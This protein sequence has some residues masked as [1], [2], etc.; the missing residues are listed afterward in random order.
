MDREPAH[1]TNRLVAFWRWL[2]NIGSNPDLTKEQ[3]K[4]LH[5]TNQA[6]VLCIVLSYSY[7]PMLLWLGLDTLALLFCIPIAI[8]HLVFWINHRQH[9]LAARILLLV[10]G[11]IQ[12]AG[13]AMAIGPAA[14]NILFLIPAAMSPFLYFS[15]PQRRYIF[16]AVLLSA[17]L[18]A[19][20]EVTFAYD[21]SPWKLDPALARWVNIATYGE[22]MLACVLFLLYFSSENFRTESALSSEKERSD[23][24][25]LNILPQSII[26]RLKSGETV[27]ADRFDDITVMFAD[28]AG[29]TPFAAKLTPEEVVDFLNRIFSSFDGLIE[30][31]RLEKIKTI[32]DAYMVVGGA[33]VANPAHLEAVLDMSLD[34]MEMLANRSRHGAPVTMRVGVHTGPAVAGIIGDKKWAYDLWGDTVNLASRLESHGVPGRIQVSE[35]VYARM[36]E[37]YCFE[38][39]GTIAVKGSG[40]MS[41]WFLTGRNRLDA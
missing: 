19:A 6:V 2:S 10:N 20:A 14:G 22:T 27:I 32:G 41:T 26:P 33:P 35:A 23:H 4:R 25:L 36:N 29:F 37:R 7:L 8:Y 17:V 5:L 1:A 12:I 3:L 30:T 16:S 9:Y 34:L 24:L 18:W 28:I 39:R 11:N 21:L 13:V 15:A 38:P 31:Y 40:E